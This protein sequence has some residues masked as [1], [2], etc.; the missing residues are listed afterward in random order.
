MKNASTQLIYCSFYQCCGSGS[1]WIQQK[2]NEY[3]NKT[4]N[5]ELFAL[6]DS[7]I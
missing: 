3:I 1:S 7:S 6:L 2:V 5:S 4:V